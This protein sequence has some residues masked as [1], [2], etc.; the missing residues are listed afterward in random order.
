MARTAPSLPFPPCSITPLMAIRNCCQAGWCSRRDSCRLLTGNGTRGAAP[1]LPR[2]PQHTEGR[3][4]EEGLAQ[5]QALLKIGAATKQA[6][7]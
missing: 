2:A 1:A 6:E 4:Q 5:R 7:K 3:S